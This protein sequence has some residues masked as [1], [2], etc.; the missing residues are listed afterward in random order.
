MSALVARSLVRTITIRGCVRV[1]HYNALQIHH[2]AIHS[3]NVRLFS[4]PPLHREPK[5]LTTEL[6][7]RQ[8]RWYAKRSKRDKG[9][10]RQ[11]RQLI[12]ALN[13]TK[14]HKSCN[15]QI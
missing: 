2:G 15:W 10:E 6:T 3:I 5:L 4:T 1:T 8:S 14:C 11:P 12:L 13:A 9:N 7:F